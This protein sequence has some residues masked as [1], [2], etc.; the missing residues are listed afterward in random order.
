MTDFLSNKAQGQGF[1]KHNDYIQR[2]KF[3][4]TG[5]LPFWIADMD[6]PVFKEISN[7]LESRVQQE[8]YA[9]QIRSQE[10]FELI[11]GWFSNRHQYSKHIVP[12]TFQSGVLSSLSFIIDMFSCEREGVIIQPPVY[13]AFAITIKGLNRKVVDN[14][15]LNTA[16]GYRIDFDH[17]EQVFSKENNKI[18]ILCHP[19]NPIGCYWSQDDLAQI[20]ALGEKYNVLIISDEI[21]ADVVF[22]GEF[23]SILHNPTCENAQVLVLNS[24]AKTF[25]APALCDGYVFATNQALS[26]KVK[27][28]SD[29]FHV[30]GGNVLTYAGTRV[31]ASHGDQW[32]KELIPV[33]E[34]FRDYVLEGLPKK[35]KCEKP[36]ATYQLSM[37]FEAY[38][39]AP[40]ELKEAFI[41]QNLGMAFGTW[42]GAGGENYVRINYATTK[43]M[44][45]QFLERVA[46]I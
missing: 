36:E 39:Y 26:K 9:Y 14:P 44:L 46:K 12:I 27:K 28:K 23:K 17:L 33:L 31:M 1:V 8:S 22:E 45:D 3:E 18:F 15:L 21:H 6:F 4:K 35:V 16:E 34:Q 7:E 13:H 25:G 11:G 5:L 41:K 30:F 43:Q 10:D 20:I 32:L 37:N 24:F 38:G 29:A 2:L 42:F 40:K 19:H